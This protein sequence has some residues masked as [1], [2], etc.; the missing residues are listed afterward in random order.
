MSF[1]DVREN[2]RWIGY[3]EREGQ[4]TQIIG[5]LEYLYNNSPK[6]TQSTEVMATT[7]SEAARGM[8]RSPAALE[9]TSSTVGT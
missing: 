6:A 7:P 5:E 4:K 9:M 2:L 3:D 8:T 1:A